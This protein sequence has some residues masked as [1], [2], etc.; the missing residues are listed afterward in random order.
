[1]TDLEDIPLMRQVVSILA[2]N[3][4]DSFGTQRDRGYALGSFARMLHETFGL[5]KW[6]NL[7]EK[8]VAYIVGRLK[9]EDAGHRKIEGKLSHLRWLVRKIGKANL[10]PRT[11]RALGIEP[12]P[13]HTRAGKTIPDARFA[14]I[15]A[16]VP[17]ERIQTALVLSR[18]L[19]LRFKEAMLWRPHRDFENGRVWVKR[20]TKGGR[21]RYLY[22]HNQAQYKAIERARELTKGDG[23]LVP[24]ECPTFEKWRQ[25]CYRELRAAGVGQAHGTLFHD[26]RRTYAVQR[27]CG[28]IARGV[29]WDPAAKLVS[30]ELGHSRTEILDWYIADQEDAASAA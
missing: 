16:A 24:R 11:N 1:M 8:H 13:R 26:A 7:G 27:F 10:V 15:L 18:E 28:L 23:S 5:Q 21:P 17:D 22:P 29:E 12:A 4:E 14:E 6:D 20:G 19:G 30:L 25:H 3:R 2:S 9:A